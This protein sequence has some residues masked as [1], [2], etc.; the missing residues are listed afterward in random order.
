VSHS[1]RPAPAD[2]GGPN[3]LAPLFAAIVL[4]EAVVIA[5]LWWFGRHFS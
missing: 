2:P 1:E 4:V 5:A 3:R